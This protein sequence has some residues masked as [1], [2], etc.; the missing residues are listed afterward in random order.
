MAE[1]VRKVKFFCN[2]Y[3]DELER[4]INSFIN[5]DNTSRELVNVSLDR[6]PLSA[7]SY[8]FAVAVIYEE[9]EENE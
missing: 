3:T 7:Y 4:E 9:V 5:E 8:R 6:K 2:E 1:R